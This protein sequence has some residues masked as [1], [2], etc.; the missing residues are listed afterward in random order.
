MAEVLHTAAKEGDVKSALAILQHQHGW[1]AKQ[2]L[3]IDVDQRIS[4]TAAL[5]QAQARVIDA[6]TSQEPEVVEYKPTKQKSL[7]AA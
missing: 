2:Q 1:V 6:L 3:S 5:E 7:K 4:I